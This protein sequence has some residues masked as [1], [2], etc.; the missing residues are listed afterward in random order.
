MSCFVS[1]FLNHS[2]SRI[3][4]ILRNWTEPIT[5][6]NIRDLM[7]YVRDD[8]VEII[9]L[10]HKFGADF[11]IKYSHSKNK[12]LVEY[13]CT[14][15]LFNILGYFLKQGACDI[16]EET[17]TLIYTSSSRTFKLLIETCD[18]N[19]NAQ[20]L[21]CIMNILDD[22]DVDKIKILAER[23][24]NFNIEYKC[25]N[26]TCPFID[27]LCIRRL[28]RIFDYIVDRGEFVSA[29]N[30]F[31]VV[32]SVFPSSFTKFFEK[33]DRDMSNE[34]LSTIVNKMNDEN[35]FTFEFFAKNNVNFNIEYT[36]NG[37]TYLR[38]DYYC[39]RGMVKVA[40]YL[41]KNNKINL[42]PQ[43]LDVASEKCPALHKFLIKRL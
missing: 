3:E 41:Y 26:G 11:N 24:V 17:C 13:L 33:R 36:Y 22:D 32:Y 8:Q 1:Q 30:T 20:R 25:E 14:R 43:S 5:E 21:T 4:D 29:E 39:A 37:K 6:E 15:S 19:T 7:Q 38:F 42:T 40:K 16:D 28:R 9:A 27:Y 10:I 35:M 2:A 12:G 18:S 34:E 31:A 23:G